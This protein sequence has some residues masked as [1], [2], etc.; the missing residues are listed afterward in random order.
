MYR[1]VSAFRL[2]PVSSRGA[3]GAKDLSPCCWGNPL[4]MNEC[5][6]LG[7][8]LSH[9]WC[10]LMGERSFAPT[11]G[12]DPFAKGIGG[13]IFSNVVYFRFIANNVF[14]VIPLPDLKTV[15]S[16][17]IHLVTPV[18]NPRTAEPRV[19]DVPRGRCFP[20]GSRIVARRCRGERYFALLLG[21]PVIYE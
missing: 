1:A 21:K 19:L 20:F 15:V 9:R 3:V 2:G 13:D 18:L 16:F 5:L 14:S 17:R 4:S 11:G 6:M 8:G 10:D 7:W 12:P